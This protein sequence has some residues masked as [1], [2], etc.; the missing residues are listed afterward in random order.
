MEFLYQLAVFGLLSCGDPR[1][2]CSN[3]NIDKIKFVFFAPED[4]G[5]PMKLENIKLEKIEIITF[6]VELFSVFWEDG[7][8]ITNFSEHIEN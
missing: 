4:L 8:I 3:L 1:T 5:V 6:I 2:I 7:K